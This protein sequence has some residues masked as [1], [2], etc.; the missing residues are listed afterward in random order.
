MGTVP[1]KT[2]R[3]NFSATDRHVIAARAGYRCSYPGCNK[4]TLGPALK[5]NEFEDTGY[6]SHIASKH[7]LVTP[8]PTALITIGSASH[9]EYVRS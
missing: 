9:S 2:A 5:S 6:A 3:E 4:L 7:R 1:K 8:P